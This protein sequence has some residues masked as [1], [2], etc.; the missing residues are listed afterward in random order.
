MEKKRAF[1]DERRE[2]TFP[3][4]VCVCV[5]ECV[6]VWKEVQGGS[7]QMELETSRKEEEAEGDL[8]W[9]WSCFGMFPAETTTWPSPVCS[10][11]SLL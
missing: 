10:I 3:V 11:D 9:P 8:G 5:C 1:G 2:S 6:C 4:C 7:S